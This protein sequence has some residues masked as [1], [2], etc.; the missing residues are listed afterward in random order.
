MR[1][2]VSPV[3][4]SSEPPEPFFSAV[5]PTTMSC[6][7]GR[8][9]WNAQKSAVG[10]AALAASLNAPVFGSQRRAL[11]SPASRSHIRRA[12]PGLTAKW[13]ATKPTRLLL[14]IFS[15]DQS[16]TLDQ[17]LALV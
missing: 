13:T 17:L 4:A 14:G 12:P 1:A 5:P 11:V 15:A 7:P 6:P 3:P 16:M 9:V 8:R 10:S 2:W